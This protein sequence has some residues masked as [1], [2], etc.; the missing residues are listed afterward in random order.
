MWATTGTPSAD[1]TAADRSADGGARGGG[2]RWI[3]V[4]LGAGVALF[5]GVL[6]Y[7]VVADDDDP[8]VP[9][10]VQEVLDE[11]RG[12][13]ESNDV[14]TIQGLV[15]DDFRRPDYLG[16]PRSNTPS[17]GVR[18]VEFFESSRGFEIDPVGDPIVTGDGPWYVA[19]VED[20]TV[21]VPN[22]HGDDLVVAYDAI[23]TFVVI[24]TD[25]G[26]RID[27]AYWAGHEVPVDSE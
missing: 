14:A 5:A 19:Q 2:R 12:A 4:V 25:D 10:D 6:A 9:D 15:T 13:M 24:E 21:V 23:T 18:T 16:D 3:V 11:F 27:D 1:P 7:V 17:R 22:D 8:T 26:L 20:W